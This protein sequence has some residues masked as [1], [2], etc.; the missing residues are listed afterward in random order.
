MKTFFLSATSVAV[1]LMLY[2]V[3]DVQAQRGPVAGQGPAI[4][5]V[6]ISYIFKNHRR[7]QGQMEAMKQDAEATKSQ[8]LKEKERIT[9]KME[10]LKEFKPG[11]EP[12]GKMEE[13]ITH[14]QAEFN[15]RG[16]LQQKDFMERESRVYMTVYKEVSD[17]VSYEAQKRGMTL[18]LRFNGDPVEAANRE[19]VLREIN[20]PIVHY[21]READITPDVLDELNRGAKPAVSGGGTAIRP[22]VAPR[23]K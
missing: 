20:K 1:L 12:Y 23:Q 16:A 19:S 9:K 17:A 7:F 18:V 3:A 8:I 6:D 14:E 5:I 22:G 21:V 13:E 4:G 11:S 15:A 10:Q 2:V